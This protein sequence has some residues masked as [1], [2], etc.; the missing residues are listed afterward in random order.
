MLLVMVELVFMINI[1]FLVLMLFSV[2]ALVITPTI[3]SISMIFPSSIL[4]ASTSTSRLL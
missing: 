4:P 3:E 2:N 1:A